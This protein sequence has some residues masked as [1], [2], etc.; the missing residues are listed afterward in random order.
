MLDLDNDLLWDSKSSSHSTPRQAHEKTTWDVEAY[1][2]FLDDMA[3]FQT[4]TAK[5]RTFFY[6]DDFEL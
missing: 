5:K 1:L 6:E 4:L 2:D 3:G